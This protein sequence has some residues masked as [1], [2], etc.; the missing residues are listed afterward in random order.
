[1]RINLNAALLLISSSTNLIDNY[2]WSRLSLTIYLFFPT[3]C[4]QIDIGQRLNRLM[5]VYFSYTAAYLVYLMQ[6]DIPKGCFSG[7]PSRSDG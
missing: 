6:A 5:K 4:Y 2:A 7:V 3:V 1:M